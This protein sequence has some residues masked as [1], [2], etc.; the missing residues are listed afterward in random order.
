MKKVKDV[1]SKI[2][3]GQELRN[4]GALV[5]DNNHKL[6]GVAEQYLVLHKDISG[7]K[8]TLDN[9]T[10]MIGKL[11]VDIN[12]VKTNVEFLK[13]GLKKKVDYDEFLALERRLSLVESK[14]SKA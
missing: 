14:L 12:I 3:V 13:G 4:L 8:N 5:E 11:A 10:E 1:K 7:I 2:D 6:S 9:H